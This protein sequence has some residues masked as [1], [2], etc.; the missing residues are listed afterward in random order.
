MDFLSNRRRTFESNTRQG[1]ERQ[2]VSF[3]E[4]RIG[5]NNIL[6]RI[7]RRQPNA[8]QNQE[9]NEII[10]VDKDLQIFQQHQLKLLNP[11][12]L[13]NAGYFS[14]D[15]QLYRHYREEQISAIGEDFKI[16]DLVN[17]HSLKH[18]KNRM[19][20]MHMGLIVIGIKGLTRK[21]LGSKVLITIYDD[22]WSD[23]K[24]SIIGLTEV[25]MTN[26]GGIFYISPD[27]LMNLKE[28]GQNIKIGIQTK[29]YE[30][31]NSGNNLLMCIG[32][33][34]KL[35]LSSNTKFKLKVNDVV[36]IMGNKGIS[37]IKPIKIDPEIYAGLE[38]N[39]NKFTKP[40][41]FT[42]DSHLLYTTSKGET[43]VRF[44][45]YNY[46]TKR[47]LDD[48]E[49]ES[50]IE[51]ESEF[52]NIE[53][54]QEGYEVDMAIEKA[55]TLAEEYHYITFKCKGCQKADMKIEECVEHFKNCLER[56]DNLGYRNNKTGLEKRD[57]DTI[58]ILSSTISYKELAELEPTSSS[59]ASPFQQT[60]PNPQ[61]IDY[62]TGNVPRR[63]A[64]RINPDTE[65]RGD[66]IKPAGKRMPIEEPIKL[67]EGGSK[68]KILNIA[69]HDPQMWDTVIDL[70]KG[71]VAAD[72]L[73]HY[74][75]TDT[76][77]MYKYLETF[78]GESAKATWES[79]KTNC[80]YDFQVLLVW[81]QIHI[82]LQIKCICY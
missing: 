7:C 47:N 33:I 20:L 45:N 81:D 36:E 73:R 50:N 63:P 35:T 5:N 11:K 57:E 58:S 43:S 64:I 39:L 74:T 77:T 44:T 76:E 29:G 54:L 17:A 38:W 78:L 37:L 80:P 13:Y 26:N 12:T 23:I 65:L 6:A 72:Y 21:N 55:E 25:D 51:T 42:P 18:L 24:K 67:Q 59:S 16:L 68:G 66:H 4:N 19:V 69:A 40:K 60:N 71:I 62:S 52:M 49:T 31:M 27:F 8:E 9:L 10:D 2:R 61:P 70:W 1:E 46:T 28:F 53:V 15:N 56:N 22:R 3:S 14:T 41:T 32:F 30:E 79:F 34:G 82:I 48:D 75:E